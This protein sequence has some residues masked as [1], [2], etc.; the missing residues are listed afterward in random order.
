MNFVQH[1]GSSHFFTERGMRASECDRSGHGGMLQQDLVNLVGSDVLASANDDVLHPSGEME[2][3]IF[4]EEALIAGAKPAVH[5]SLRV[6]LGIIF[7]PAKHA[8]SLNDNLPALVV[9]EMISLFVHDAD[10]NA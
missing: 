3:T 2:I 7:I 5:Q 9:S 1:N 10:S 6:G 4:I 8:R